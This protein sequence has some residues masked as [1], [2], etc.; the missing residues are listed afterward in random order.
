MYLIELQI[1]V[2]GNCFIISTSCELNLDKSHNNP[3]KPSTLILK[4]TVLRQSLHVFNFINYHFCLSM[5]SDCKKGPFLTYKHPLFSGSYTFNLA[6]VDFV[7]IVR[8]SNKL[9]FNCC[10]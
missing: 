2:V 4:L 3:L 6:S 9:N 10:Y 5:Y 8:H 7:F 1:F